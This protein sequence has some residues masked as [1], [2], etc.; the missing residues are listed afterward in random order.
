M[1]DYVYQFKRAFWKYLFYIMVPIIIIGTII[2]S[3]LSVRLTNNT[4]K[5]K[6][7]M[8]EQIKEVVDVRM[9][10]YIRT[11]QKVQSEETVKHFVQSVDYRGKFNADK[12]FAMR[13]ELRG[14]A[15]ANTFISMGVFLP[16]NN[17]LADQS[18]V[19]S[20]NEYYD[21]YL[22]NSGQTEE[23]LMETLDIQGYRT[24]FT[25]SEVGD[26]IVLYTQLEAFSKSENNKVLIMLIS[27]DDLLKDIISTIETNE[28][29][30]TILKPDGETIFR[31]ENIENDSD[32]CT[33]IKSSTVNLKYAFK[34]DQKSMLVNTKYFTTAFI[35]FL[36]LGFAIS[37]LL[38]RFAVRK[39]QN[40]IA[41][42]QNEGRQ[43]GEKLNQQIEQS[44]NQII[45]DL[46]YNAHNK[47]KYG[48]EYQSTLGI[49]GSKFSVIVMEIEK[50][51]WFEENSQINNT[52]K[53]EEIC[54]IVL[55]HISSRQ[56][57]SRHIKI[58]DK[59]V[60]VLGYG[61]RF[62]VDELLEMIEIA[63]STK[64]DVL[65]KIGVG[66]EVDSLEQIWSAY[67]EATTTLKY[68][69]LFKE[70]NIVYYSEIGE[71]DKKKPF[72][73]AGKEIALVRSVKQGNEESVSEL[74]NELQRVNFYDSH[75]PYNSIKRLVLN[76]IATIYSLADDIYAENKEEY[77][78]IDNICQKLLRERNDEECFERIKDVFLSLCIA[79]KSKTNEAD[80]DVE[81]KQIIEFINT[82]YMK[83][84]LSLDMVA[85]HM[86]IEYH[87]FSKIFKKK[88]GN[89]FSRYLTEL[90]LEKA[91]SL[92]EVGDQTVKQ[93]ANSVGFSDDKYFR[94]LFKKYYKTT[95]MSYKKKI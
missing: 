48:V 3:S 28:I 4:E 55:Q 71:I 44:R 72:Y 8:M 30:F 5:M 10:E 46:L 27:M 74:L 76:T 43:L 80:D 40:P 37:L 69:S 18:G 22:K 62:S 70:S 79:Y 68:E 42:V 13:D 21:R 23:Q 26:C 91:K 65:V 45:I 67:D 89:S 24:E 11:M 92:L 64:T 87:Y 60:F 61:A 41:A 85:E 59:D 75:L 50:N 52:E 14:Y 15:H 95:P 77:K 19:Y 90:R 34:F 9:I 39:L 83:P 53:C 94:Q 32:E 86:G 51:E 82:N 36:I 17:L 57:T 58:E 35:A 63:L 84:D 16:K 25:G 1:A 47:E 7:T 88:L 81:K 66:N 93:I 33:F 54:S 31:T 49:D 56:I 29:S 73:T 38:A 6:S 12:Y 20:F 78:K 2:L